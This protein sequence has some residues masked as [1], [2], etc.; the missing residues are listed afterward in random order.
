MD[1]LAPVATLA[2]VLS[3]RDGGTKAL[4]KGWERAHKCQFLQLR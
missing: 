2:A 3:A 1:D 4:L